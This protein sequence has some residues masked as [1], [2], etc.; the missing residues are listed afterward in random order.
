MRTNTP[1]EVTITIRVILC[2]GILIAICLVALAPIL[3]HDYSDIILFAVT[4]YCE[5]AYCPRILSRD[6]SQLS[7]TPRVLKNKDTWDSWR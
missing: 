4:E 2:F 6:R 3:S 7:Q 1:A 5:C